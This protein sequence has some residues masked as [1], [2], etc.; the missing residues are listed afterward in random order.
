MKTGFD[1]DFTSLKGHLNE[2]LSNNDAT[3]RDKVVTTLSQWEALAKSQSELVDDFMNL[4][5]VLT[6]DDIPRLKSAVLTLKHLTKATKALCEYI[7]LKP[8]S[9][10]TGVHTRI[11]DL[12]KKAEANVQEIISLAD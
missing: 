4:N 5:E 12:S 1:T 10:V 11:L 7:D 8:S 6:L 9:Y 2:I 3:S